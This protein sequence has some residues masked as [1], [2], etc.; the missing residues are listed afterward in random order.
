MYSWSHLLT[1]HTD[2][3]GNSKRVEF[4]TAFYHLKNILSYVKSKTLGR[5]QF[6]ALFGEHLKIHPSMDASGW[7]NVFSILLQLHIHC[8]RKSIHKIHVT[9]ISLGKHKRHGYIT[10]LLTE[11]VTNVECEVA[12]AICLAWLLIQRWTC[13]VQRYCMM[14]YEYSTWNSKE[15]TFFSHH[16]LCYHSNLDMC[17]WLFWSTVTQGTISRSLVHSLGHLYIV[18]LKQQSTS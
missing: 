17:F 12:T 15:T 13:R 11:I 8:H 2:V 3:R 10:L 6:Q 7:D 14:L 9:I 4:W 16:Y 18:K 5:Q 1:W